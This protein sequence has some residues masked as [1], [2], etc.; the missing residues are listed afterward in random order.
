MQNNREIE[1]FR[2]TVESLRESQGPQE[3]KTE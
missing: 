1:I 3:E 2:N